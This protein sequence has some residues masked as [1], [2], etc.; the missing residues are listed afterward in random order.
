MLIIGRDDF[1]MH[2]R[3]DLKAYI[4]SNNIDADKYEMRT[5]FSKELYMR[6]ANTEKSKKLIEIYDKKISELLKTGEIEKIFDKW[7]NPF[8]QFRP[9][10]FN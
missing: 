9:R 8:P 1:F 2:P 5:V 10:E 6:F 4:K 3:E 7:E